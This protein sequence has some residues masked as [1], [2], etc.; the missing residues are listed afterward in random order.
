MNPELWLLLL[1]AALALLWLDNRRVQEIAVARCRQAC[2]SAGVQFLDDT[3]PIW[4]LGLM[5]DT[6][7]TLRLRRVYT[8]D[9]ST[10]LGERHRGSITM[11]GRVPAALQLGEQ[12][13]FETSGDTREHHS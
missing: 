9:Y 10:A 13:I 3:A 4:R 7:G 1:I 12:T 5:R 6:R 2:Q 11:L 8:F